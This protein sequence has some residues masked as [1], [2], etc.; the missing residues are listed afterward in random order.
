MKPLKLLHIGRAEA[1]ERNTE[2]SAFTES[3]EKVSLPCGL[4]PSN[5]I[6]AMPNADIII[7]DAIADVPR[8][9]ISG[10]PHL[11]MI[12]SE[13]VAFNR[14]DL[15]AADEKGVYVCNSAGMNAS[16]VAE[17]TLLLML[18]VLK[19]AINNDR[20]VREGRQI[21]VKE[22][23]MA[24]GDLIDLSDCK[25]SLIGFGNIGKCTAALLKAFHVKTFY[26]QRHR[27]DEE[28]EKTYGVTFLPTQDELL[29][30]SDIVSL[31][32]PVTP[33]T[34]GMCDEKFFS[35]MKKGSYFINTARGELVNDEA[36]INA[37]KS[38]HLKMAGLDT[39]DHEPVQKNHILLN[40]PPEIASKI[41]FSPHIGGITGSSFKRS[42]RMIWE[43]VRRIAEGKVPDRVVNH[44]GK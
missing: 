31:H 11:K 34:T 3:V 6:K 8:D 5:Y 1:F 22:G 17:Q 12:H 39:L 24:R 40:Q 42:Y 27:A 19:D 2:K 35:K 9:L 23:Y 33:E 36:L 44:T 43:N 37:L 26:T 4:P 15:K 13:G 14:F 25:V 38:G 10:L 30:K 18:G 32:L 41:I 16:A 20:A 28:T 7:A 21:Q 29:Q